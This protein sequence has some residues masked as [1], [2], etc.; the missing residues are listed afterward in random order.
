MQK[1]NEQIEKLKEQFSVVTQ[2][3]DE[4]INGNPLYRILYVYDY[5]FD[6][7]NGSYTFFYK[8]LYFDKEE[9]DITSQVAIP[10]YKW[11]ID[12]SLEVAIR[13]LTLPDFP[14][15][16]VE[17]EDKEGNITIEHR[18]ER[19]DIQLRKMTKLAPLPMLLEFYAKDLDKDGTF[20]LK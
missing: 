18:K 12:K 19:A 15:K 4:V 9:N 17:V 11:I 16:S 1:M 2:L 20:S 13:N 3:T 8:I 6:E 14:P 5:R 7:V 10:S